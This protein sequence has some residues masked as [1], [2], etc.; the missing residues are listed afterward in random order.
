MDVNL[1]V[2]VRLELSFSDI[3][4]SITI[5]DLS[6]VLLASI[7]DAFDVTIGTFGDMHITSSLQLQ[8]YAENRN[9]V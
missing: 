7:T 1:N 4:F 8:L 2:K 3:S 5:N 9:P 6:M